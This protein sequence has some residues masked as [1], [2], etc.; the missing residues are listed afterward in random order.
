MKVNN[1]QK[2]G[3]QSHSEKIVS[4]SLANYEKFLINV[5]TFQFAI[6]NILLQ[7]VNML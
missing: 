6:R 7:T 1:N 3:K 4:I 2:A 5:N